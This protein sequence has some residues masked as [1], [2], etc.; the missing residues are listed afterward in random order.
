MLNGNM[1]NTKALK[2]SDT[3]NSGFTLLEVLIAITITGA[4]IAVLSS[5]LMQTNYNQHLYEQRF[6]AMMN[7][8]G[9]LAELICGSD[10]GSSGD[11]KVF[12]TQYYWYASEDTLPDGYTKIT[13]NVEWRDNHGSSHQTYLI[14]YRSPE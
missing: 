11:F 12:G 1:K 2:N 5:A 4:V 10:S 9:K 8:R 13:L 6:M 14:G 7:G 3:E